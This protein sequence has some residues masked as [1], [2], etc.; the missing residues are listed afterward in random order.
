[1]D[2]NQTL[3]GKQKLAVHLERLWSQT[4]HF[5]SKFLWSHFALMHRSVLTIVQ[6][7]DCI[8]TFNVIIFIPHCIALT[9]KTLPL[10][11][12]AK[13]TLFV[14]SLYKKR[15]HSEV[16]SALKTLTMSDTTRTKP[17]NWKEKL[18][19][20]IMEVSTKWCGKINHLVNEGSDWKSGLYCQ[21]QLVTRK[22]PA[23]LSN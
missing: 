21:G 13:R 10:T 12:W 1:M 16:D 3:T 19:N 5:C 18:N 15:T 6:Y 7:K 8:T 14:P 4:F 9:S 20:E 11:V 22:R 17:A 23:C 2:V